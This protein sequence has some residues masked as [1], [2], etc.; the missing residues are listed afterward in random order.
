[1]FGA[2]K[3]K[4]KNMK[5]W[6][7]VVV[8][9]RRCYKLPFRKRLWANLHC[10]T[11]D[12]YVVFNLDK[13]DYHDYI[14]EY[15]RQKSR[16]INGDY[17]I[18]M[19]DKLLYEQIFS[20]SIRVPVNYAYIQNKKIYPLGDDTVNETTLLDFIK[21][22]KRV[23]L[24]LNN[25]G[26][27]KGIHVISCENENFFVDDKSYTALDLLSFVIGSHDSILSEY[28]YQGEWG[29][30]LFPKT[31]NTTRI[32]VAREKNATEYKIVG[33]VQRIGREASIPVDN[34]DAGG[35]VA[36]IDLETGVLSNAASRVNK[37]GTNMEFMDNHPDTGAPI[38]GK[39]V[40][41]WEE[42]KQQM[43][44]LAYQY[45]YINFFAW[46]LVVLDD[47]LCALEVNA[48]SGVKMFQLHRGVRN[49]AFGDLY[50]SYGVIK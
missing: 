11:N 39:Q 20:R 24:K 12:E 14:S 37:D 22:K 40:P 4:Y 19:D 17:R 33:A 29:N 48:S 5:M 6:L 26:G 47:G 2:L 7:A 34:A 8:H 49:G 41:R 38:T 9:S 1:M 45:P 21:E 28:I 3:K 16:A 23:M 50:K 25:S 32:V 35:L 44:S 30:S 43:L 31:V 27:G 46:D 42:L 18:A 10:F 15:E 36:E 13:N